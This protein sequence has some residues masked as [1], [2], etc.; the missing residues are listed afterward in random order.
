[1][2]KPTVLLLIFLF[3]FTIA[4]ADEPL[5]S[6]TNTV[7]TLL[8]VKPSGIFIVET[9]TTTPQPDMSGSITLA[10]DP[11]P[12]PDVTGYQIFYRLEGPI[13]STGIYD[14]MYDVGN[15]TEFTIYGLQVG[16]LYYFAAKAYDIAGN[17]S[18]F[19]EDASAVIKLKE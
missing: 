3:L 9:T 6:S 10:W 1:M 4:F 7:S 15:V 18:D 14:K 11:N 16:K 5:V 8:P 12:E 13:N 17:E 19:S 2:K